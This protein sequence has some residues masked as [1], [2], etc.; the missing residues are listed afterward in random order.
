VRSGRTRTMPVRLVALGAF[1]FIILAVAIVSV[2]TASW[3]WAVAAEALVLIWFG[4]DIA[5]LRCARK[6]G[7]ASKE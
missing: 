2:A 6:S 7:S 5:L 3:R 4:F 1:T